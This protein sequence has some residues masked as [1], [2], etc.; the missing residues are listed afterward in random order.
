MKK[1]II[2]L[3]GI[4]FTSVNT[5]ADTR[6]AVLLLHNGQGKTFETDQLQAAVNEAVNGDTIC[7]SEGSFSVGDGLTIDKKISII[8]AGEISKIIGNVKVAIDDAPTLSSRLLDAL[9]INGDLTIAN[10]VYGVKIR[11]IW[12]GGK[13]SSSA[14]TKIEIDRCF[15]Y[16]YTASPKIKSATFV[17]SILNYIRGGSAG[18][19]TNF[20]NCS[21]S[22]VVASSNGYIYDVTFE[23]CIIYSHSNGAEHNRNIY[24]N[25]LIKGVS[26]TSTSEFFIDPTTLLN[27]Y[28]VSNLTI[29]QELSNNGSFPTF[30]LDKTAITAESLVTAGYVGTDGTAVGHLGGSA[31]YTLTPSGINVIES[32]LKLDAEKKQLNVTL[33]VT[34]N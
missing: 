11:K 15:I 29:N 28:L 18:N 6:A 23:N 33:K 17:G 2:T 10:E 9:R 16:E 24:R 5:Y 20:F 14:I 27:C 12:L 4:I 7:L 1:I 26:S 19:D 25:T 3:L 22:F 31:P 34:S 30:L 21:I 32:L 13:L 8:G